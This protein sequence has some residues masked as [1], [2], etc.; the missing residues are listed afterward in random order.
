M[1]MHT[2]LSVM[3]KGAFSCLDT[4]FLKNRTF[5]FTI[6]NTV[7][8]DPITSRSAN[9]AYL[10]TRQQA[11][12]HYN[13]IMRKKFMTAVYTLLILVAVLAIST[14]AVLHLPVFGA[15]P[16]G[17]RLERMMRSPHYKDGEFHNLQPTVMM[18]GNKNESKWG[19]MLKFLFGDK[20]TLRPSEPLQMAKHDL[21]NLPADKD[22][23]VWF[24]H[25]SYLLSLHGTTFLI[26]P[27]LCSGSPVSF[28][29]KPF[30][31]T[32]KYKPEDMP[33]HI[34]YL[35]ISHDHYD[36]LDY[37]CVKRIS[38]RVGH[39]VC[40]LGV[41]AHFESWGYDTEKIIEM[42]WFEDIKTADGITIHCLPARHF[43]GRSL[44]RNPTLW[45]SFLVDTPHGNIFLGGDS[46]YG[47]H[48]KEIAKRHPRIDL[49]ILENGQYNRQWQYI[50]TMPQ[51]LGVIATELH[52][53][54][55]ITV[56]HSKYAL[57]RHSWDE[58]LKSELAARDKYHLNLTI[59]QLGEITEIDL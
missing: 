40:P 56:H 11:T 26:D 12:I 45:A 20:S 31:G 42:D 29:N 51:Y 46:G 1:A 52:A 30:K 55:V 33:D 13:R 37:E 41:G 27:T 43:S 2:P 17:A 39:V 4:C 58:P 16:E 19:S 54:Q 5:Y 10:C 47:R 28:F 18:V 14:V 49:A 7:Y 53:R 36:H 44:K 9:I 15:Q 8:R 59:A 3:R 6:C 32:D 22:I 35:V 57:A 24:G 48:F 34:D 50:H 23:Y 21:K 38:K 25:S